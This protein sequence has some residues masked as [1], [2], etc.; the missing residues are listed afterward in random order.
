MDGDRAALD[1]IGSDLLDP[2][3]M[4][5][6][7]R[8]RSTVALASASRRAW[9]RAA[10]SRRSNAYSRLRPRF[11]TDFTRGGCAQHGETNCGLYT[12]GSAAVRWLCGERRRSR[13]GERGCARRSVKGRGKAASEGPHLEAEFGSGSARRGR[14]RNDG[15]AAEQSS[16]TAAMA[17]AEARVSARA[18]VALRGLGFQGRGPAP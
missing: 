4:A 9:R 6:V 12:S 7:E 14:L 13:V 15:A 10:V 11:D 18:R 1:Y 2:N 3:P 16:R 8:G 17:R 5:R